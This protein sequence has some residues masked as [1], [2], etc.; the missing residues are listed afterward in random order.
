MSNGNTETIKTVKEQ[1]VKKQEE[2]KN[3]ETSNFDK[4]AKDFYVSLFEGMTDE[5]RKRN[6]LIDVEVTVKGNK[7]KVS[8]VLEAVTKIEVVN[9]K[10]ATKKI[11]TEIEE[12]K[13]KLIEMV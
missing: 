5:N 3:L 7:I 2:L 10:D 11:N 6:K 8:D 1:I 9:N 13:N 12:L 4:K